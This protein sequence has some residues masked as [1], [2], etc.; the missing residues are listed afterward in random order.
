MVFPEK[1]KFECSMTLK[2]FVKDLLCKNKKER[3]TAE[4]ALQDMWFLDF[5]PRDEI[6]KSMNI[7]STAFQNN[8]HNS[9]EKGGLSTSDGSKKQVDPSKT[10]VIKGF[11]SAIE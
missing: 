8:L 10:D 7:F 1:L 9:E 4:E 6:T 11:V 5:R 3:P 2:R